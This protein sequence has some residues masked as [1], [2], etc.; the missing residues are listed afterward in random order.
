[1]KLTLS[2]KQ[3]EKIGEKTGWMKSSQITEYENLENKDIPFASENYKGFLIEAF[4]CHMTG[5]MNRFYAKVNGVLVPNAQ[6]SGE[7]VAIQNAKNLIDEAIDKLPHPS[8]KEDVLK[9]LD[10][11]RNFKQNEI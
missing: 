7:Q 4:E 9:E 8:T 6:G 10:R 1:M 5:K 11:W 2:K 3:W